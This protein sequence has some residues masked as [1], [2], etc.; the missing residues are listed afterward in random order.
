M[1]TLAELDKAMKELNEMKSELSD[2]IGGGEWIIC[3]YDHFTPMQFGAWK[4]KHNWNINGKVATLSA[5]AI[6]DPGA[7]AEEELQPILDR[8]M[9]LANE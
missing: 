8:I 6:I 1:K 4:L 7:Y 3:F 5:D 9:E 2:R